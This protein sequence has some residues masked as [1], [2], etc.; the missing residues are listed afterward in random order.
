M[1]LESRSTQIGLLVALGF[2]QKHIRSFYLS[3]GFV[4]SLFGGITGLVISYFY[5]TLVFRILNSLWFDIVRTN[6]LEIQLLP[7]TLVIGLVIS[8]IVSLGAIAISLRR[9]QKQ[10]AV[11]LQKQI[12]VKESR[13]KSR[14]LNGVLWALW[15][16]RL[17]CLLCSCLLS[18]RCF[19]IFCVGRINA[20][21][22]IIAFQKDADETRG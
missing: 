1:N 17:W 6:V 16:C 20:A 12:A 2:Q 7:S 5:T 19:P 14:L 9:F 21:R 10:K 8:L 3:E 18:S 13:L 15:H 11:E 22:I 4:V